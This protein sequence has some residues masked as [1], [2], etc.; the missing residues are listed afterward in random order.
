[1]L[2]K[3]LIILSKIMIFFRKTA[4]FSNIIYY[5]PVNGILLFT[6]LVWSRVLH[7]SLSC[8]GSHSVSQ[9]TLRF[10]SLHLPQTFEWWEYSCKLLFPDKILIIVYWIKLPILNYYLLYWHS[11]FSSF[12]NIFISYFSLILITRCRATVTSFLFLKCLIMAIFMFYL[13]KTLKD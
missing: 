4:S 13:S 10:A 5:Y 11:I 6:Y 7:C 2:F 9:A 3:N 1:M 8:P 12:N